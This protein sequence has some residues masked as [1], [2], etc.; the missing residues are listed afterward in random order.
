MLCLKALSLVTCLV[1]HLGTIRI[2]LIV[3]SFV[4]GSRTDKTALLKPKA[5]ELFKKPKKPNKQAK[6]NNKKPTPNPKKPRL[7]SQ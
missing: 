4:P 3:Y 1:F 5:V 7:F 2:V 6:N